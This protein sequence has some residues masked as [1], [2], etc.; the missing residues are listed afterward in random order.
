MFNYKYYTTIFYI[1]PFSPKLANTCT[2]YNTTVCVT[3]WEYIVYFDSPKTSFGH[4]TKCVVTFMTSSG[5][6]LT[7][8]ISKIVF[9][10]PKLRNC[11]V[12]AKLLNVERSAVFLQII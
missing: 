4:F 5:V 9:L 6:E 1:Q 2:I 8:M 7:Y 3:L 10:P 11:D 12:C